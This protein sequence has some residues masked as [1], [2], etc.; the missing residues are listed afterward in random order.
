[1]V[2]NGQVATK[3][4][5]EYQAAEAAASEQEVTLTSAGISFSS[6]VWS[7]SVLPALGQKNR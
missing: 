1:M 7:M 2:R 6:S 5:A 4:Q 3:S